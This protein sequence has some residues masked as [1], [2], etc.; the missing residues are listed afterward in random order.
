MVMAQN[1]I[2]AYN[3]LLL[4]NCPGD[5]SLLIRCGI[6]PGHMRD[7]S[8]ISPGYPYESNGYTGYKLGS[9]PWLRYEK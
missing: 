9:T 2:H 1:D 3:S 5:I 4:P 7:I 8:G 6:T